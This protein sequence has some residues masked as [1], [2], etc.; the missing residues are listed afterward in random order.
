VVREDWVGKST[1]L[2]LVL[3]DLFLFTSFVSVFVLFFI[4][5][6]AQ[7]GYFDL[8]TILSEGCGGGWALLV[9]IPLWLASLLVGIV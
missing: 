5:N 6:K 9:L 1:D 3:S 4:L 2:M 8:S 7:R